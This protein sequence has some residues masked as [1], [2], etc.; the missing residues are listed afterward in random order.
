MASATGVSA[1][2]VADR[3]GF[4]RAAGSAE[5]ILADESIG[6]VVIATR[7]STHAALA[8]AGLR[9]GKAVFV[10]KPLALTE[11]ELVDLEAALAEGGLLMVGFNRRFAPLVQRL[12][13]E[14]HGVTGRVVAVRVNAGPLP[15]EHWLHDPAEGGGRLLGE[16]CHFVDLLA[17]LAESEPIS[18]H[19]VA[20]PLADHP[21]E[22]S[23]RLAAVLRFADGSVG[24]LVYAGDGDARLAKERVEAFGGGLSAV[25][26][27][28]KRLELYRGGRR[29]VVK[30]AQDKG[31]RAEIARFV[32]AAA[33][34][35][36]TSLTRVVPLFD[37]GD[38]RARRVA[39][40][41][42]PGRALDAPADGSGNPTCHDPLGRR[43]DTDGSGPGA[44][45]T[46]GAAGIP[47]TR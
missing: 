41:R 40:H 39:S 6:A 36:R 9:A 37:P 17:H 26:D 18:A 42:P 34:R 12:R 31:H 43:G 25:I 28:F 24:S 14:L 3:F 29:S 11:D 15:T 16:G 45:R 1:A 38:A 32:A 21:L 19:A 20:T 44:R 47:T 22:C 4:E 33:G 35:E 30:Q 23:D 2:D 5:E 7:H 27:D 13:E 8:A 46:T 10:E